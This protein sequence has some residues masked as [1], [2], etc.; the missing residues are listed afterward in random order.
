MEPGKK[1]DQQTN[2]KNKK[3]AYFVYSHLRLY[4]SQVMINAINMAESVFAAFDS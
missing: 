1:A 3:L 2:T 4:G